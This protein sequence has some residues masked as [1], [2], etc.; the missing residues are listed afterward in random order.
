MSDNVYNSVCDEFFVEMYVNTE[1][2]LP[3]QRDT[4][5][6]FFER[7][8]RQYPEMAN[9]SRKEDGEY[10]LQ[11]DQDGDGCRWVGLEGYRL[12][13][14]IIN[15]EKLASAYEQHRLVLELMPYM[16]GVSHLDVDSLDVSF[17]MDFDYTGNHDEVIAE[18]LG[19][20][21]AFSGMAE[22]AGAKCI[23]YSPSIVIALGED[24]RTQV[25]V[26][27]ESRT[28][29]Y[30]PDKKSKSD[31][32]ISLCMTVRQYPQISGKFDALESFARQCRIAEEIMAE[33]IMPEFIRPLSN[34]IAQK[35]L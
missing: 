18:A 21:S 10:C 2:E 33:K 8:Q 3:S 15:P 30:D 7:L 5:L 26:S 25:R 14:G 27:V 28:S 19:A 29:V 24:N 32:A 17:G 1:L 12:S 11:Q 22:I 23:D 6:T 9:F 34:V 13:S 4:I 20:G 16:L 31:E 35:R